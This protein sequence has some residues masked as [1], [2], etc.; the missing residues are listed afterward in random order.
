MFIIIVML[1]WCVEAR[2]AE[3]ALKGKLIEEEVELDQ[4]MSL[5]HVNVCLRNVQKYFTNDGWKAVLHLVKA[6][7]RETVWYCGRCTNVIKDEEEDSIVCKSCLVWF[8]FRCT[9]LKKS[10]KMVLSSM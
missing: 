4:N 3:S 2:V 5:H 10:C 8:H 7:K 6:V 9:G 1:E